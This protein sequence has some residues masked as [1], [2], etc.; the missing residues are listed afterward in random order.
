MLPQQQRGLHGRALHISKCG[1]LTAPPFYWHCRVISD[2][3]ELRTH[4]SGYVQQTSSILFVNPLN[5]GI[6][7]CQKDDLN[8]RVTWGGTV[9]YDQRDEAPSLVGIR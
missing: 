4:Q 5:C 6:A 3:Y 2:R 1:S 7:S 8:I 9:D